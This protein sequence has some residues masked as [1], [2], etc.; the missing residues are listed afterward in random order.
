MMI[1]TVQLA[2]A[3][4]MRA[5]ALR[6]AL[7]RS[8]PWHIVL[9]RKPDPRLKGV[10]VLDEEALNGL[11]GPLAS[12]ERVVLIARKD[13]RQL[14]A[15]WDAGIVSV[16]AVDDS[17]DTVLLAI[18]AASLRRPRV[19]AAAAPGANSPNSQPD[20]APITPDIQRHSQKRNKMR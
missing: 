12:P 3:D 9:V 15:A 16:V 7:L 11:C 20:A 19:R 14:S 2:L 10:L 17:P 13:P 6:E 5:A 18:M 1:T 4:P 8:G